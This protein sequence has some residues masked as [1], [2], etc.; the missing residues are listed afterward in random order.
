MSQIDAILKEQYNRVFNHSLKWEIIKPCL[1]DN[2]IIK[3]DDSSKYE[4]LRL[5][6]EANVNIKFFIPASGSGSRMFTFLKD[7]EEGK[8]QIK[9]ENVVN[10]FRSIEKFAF[11]D[12]LPN[13]LKEQLELENNYTAV[14]SYLFSENGFNFKNIPKGLIPFHRYPDYILNPFQEQVLQAHKIRKECS[15]LHFTIQDKYKNAIGH[16]IR[17]V[18]SEEIAA[19][20]EFSV[21]SCDSDVQA[22]D[23]NG[24]PVID[25][26]G[27]S[28]KMPAGHGAL[29]KNLNALQDEIILVKNIDNVVYQDKIDDSIA[30]WKE[31]V[32]LMLLM[33]SEA[34]KIWENPSMQLFY[35]FN[36]RFQLLNEEELGLIKDSLQ[37]KE[38]LD[39]PYRICGMVRNQGEP[40]GGPFWV[41]NN[42]SISKQIVEK[43]QIPDNK[44]NRTIIS[45]STHFN[46]VIMVVSNRSLTGEKYDLESFADHSSYLIVE[47][48]Y[49]GQEIKFAELP[50]LWNGGMANWNSIFVEVPDTVFSP[51]KSL[52][53][54]LRPDHMGELE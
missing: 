10:F 25:L 16:S 19:K 11:W 8:Y 29:L 4:C 28:L 46:P 21:Q 14:L 20:I 38:V 30:M 26:N 5:F 41:K 36:K 53:D 22:F 50:G 49:K 52:M 48:N 13:W 12:L 40:G 44:S 6:E 31:L 9:D 37:V 2:G 23:L 35:D 32:G 3:L 1:V 42:G 24:V 39:R 54:L 45:Q 34:E 17:E 43:S 51:V 15:S 18:T 47:K 7:I 33:R 27:H